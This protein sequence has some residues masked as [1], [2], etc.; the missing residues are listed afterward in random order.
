[1]TLRLPIFKQKGRPTC[2]PCSL[3][4][5]LHYFGTK[6]SQADIEKLVDYEEGKPT[7]SI[8]LALAAK[9]AG[10]DAELMS[11]HIKPSKETFDREYYKQNIEDYMETVIKLTEEAK[12]LGVKLTEKS[13]TL[14]KLLPLISKDRIPIVLVNSRTIKKEPGFMGH[15]LT[16]V[17]FNNKFV[18]VNDSAGKNGRRMRIIPRNLFENARKSKGTDEDILIVSKPL[19]KN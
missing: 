12:K 14:E 3:R 5:V 16:L 10:Y 17:G 6:L 19:I 9:K 2:G 18:H 1:M 4:Q 7:L 15:Y 8:K 13:I 11:I